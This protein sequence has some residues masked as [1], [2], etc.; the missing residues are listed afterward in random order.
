[1]P[2]FKCADLGMDCKWTAKAKSKDDLMKK[3][4]EHGKSA[5][6]MTT[7]DPDMMKKIDGLIKK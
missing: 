1:M 6:N 5:H 7:I 2:S 4:A 3:I